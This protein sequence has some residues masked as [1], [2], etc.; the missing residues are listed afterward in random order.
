L[1]NFELRKENFGHSANSDTADI[2]F[3]KEVKQNRQ[4][5]NSE[6]S[7]MERNFHMRYPRSY[8]TKIASLCQEKNIK[9]IFLY[10]PEYGRGI[11][12]PKEKFTYQKY[13]K[14]IMPPGEIFEN[15]NY[16]HDDNH[17]N[18][19]GAKV[20]STWVAKHLFD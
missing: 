7:E 15:C 1:E 5:D 14:I 4:K 2:N 18:I 11:K 10:L 9:L 13:G 16:W 17:L 12:E 3:L 19:E 8:L 20:L 6:L